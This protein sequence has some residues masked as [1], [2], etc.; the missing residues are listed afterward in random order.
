MLLATS[1]R[2]SSYVMSTLGSLCRLNLITSSMLPFVA[3][4]AAVIAE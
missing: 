2:L 4:S 1:L 3:S